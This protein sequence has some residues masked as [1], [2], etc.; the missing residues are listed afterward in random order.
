MSKRARRLSLKIVAF[1]L[2][3]LA[4]LVSPTSETDAFSI[5]DPFKAVGHALGEVARGVGG[6]FGQGLAGFAGPTI[7]AFAD[8]ANQVVAEAVAKLD[9][10]LTA[11][12]NQ[13]DAI[14]AKNLNDLDG[15]IGKRISDLDQILDQKIGAIDIVGTKLLQNT[16]DS[17]VT[18]LRYAA[19]L[20]LISAIVFVAA[21]AVM[22]RK[23][24]EIFPS[25]T[26]GAAMITAVIGAL[27]VILAST[28]LTPPAGARIAKLNSDF[29]NA[30][31]QAFRYAELNDAVLYSKQL[32]VIDPS[33]T[34]YAAL[35][36]IAEI[37]RDVLY[38]PT[39]LKSST[40]ANELL[41]RVRRL[42]QFANDLTPSDKLSQFD[43]R[44]V[45]ATTA[46]VLWQLARTKQE[47][48]AALCAAARAVQL[49]GDSEPS[50]ASPFIWLSY[51]YL[52]WGQ[53]LFEGSN[54]GVP[55]PSG[56]LKELL[57]SANKTIIRFD[58]EKTQPDSIS[59]I[60]KFNKDAASYY[61]EAGRLYTS[62]IVA[63]AEYQFRIDPAKQK[64]KDQRDSFAQQ[65]LDAWAKFAANQRDSDASTSDVGL[66]AVGLPAAL[67]A[68]AQAILTNPAPASRL[69]SSAACKAIIDARATNTVASRAPYEKVA[70]T[71]K[72]DPIYALAD[73]YPS[74]GI[75]N[76]I[77]V[78]QIAY[79]AQLQA[80]ETALVAAF[81]TD[82]ANET[83]ARKAIAARHEAVISSL[84]SCLVERPDAGFGRSGCSDDEVKQNGTRPFQEWLSGVPVR[85]ETMRFAMVR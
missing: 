30:A 22:N 52:R 17:F 78:D 1:Q 35:Q 27:T 75:K 85:A 33:S 58:V 21:H 65:L 57:Q 38:R 83:P 43:Q 81:N 67:A 2:V 36:K 59:H 10:M 55:C 4:F 77:C 70:G 25:P 46:V 15:R 34:G 74:T 12:L 51:G 8:Q 18:I 68:R 84:V 61:R 28:L 47:E 69:M 5:G 41:P 72:P 39:T 26:T 11:R 13:T 40:G 48:A 82:S 6:I 32:T 24:G 54:L 16:E 56:D 79:D 71:N 80:L 73:I 63:D 62:M 3:C 76:A 14:L 9:T 66:A 53:M 60:V 29:Q 37:Q 42:L 44:E 45:N 19:I 23:I 31:M 50:Q 7:G 20:A 49:F 64:H